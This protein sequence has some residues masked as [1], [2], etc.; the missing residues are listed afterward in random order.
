MQDAADLFDDQLTG[1]SFSKYIYIYIWIY[2]SIFSLFL[3]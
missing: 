3:T 1:L 2:K